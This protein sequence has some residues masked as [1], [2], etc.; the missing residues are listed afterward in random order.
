MT[1]HLPAEARRLE[2]LNYTR[3]IC[4][5]PTPDALWVLEDSLLRLRLGKPVTGALGHALVE[6][7]RAAWP[8]PDSTRELAKRLITQRGTGAEPSK[9]E[10]EELLAGVRAAARRVHRWRPLEGTRSPEAAYDVLWHLVPRFALGVSP[11]AI[12]VALTNSQWAVTA[13]DGQLP[14]PSA[15]LFAHLHSGGC[16][17]PIPLAHHDGQRT[18]TGSLPN[19]GLTEDCYISVTASPHTNITRHDY[20]ERLAAQDRVR[21]AYRQRLSSDTLFVAEEVIDPAALLGEG[22]VIR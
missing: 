16:H 8:L 20:R 15:Q 3:S 22:R 6:V 10:L 4:P 18:G 21:D 12:T 11:G 7:R 19:C 17:T 1:R 2:L 14:Q 13:P 9:N 5:V